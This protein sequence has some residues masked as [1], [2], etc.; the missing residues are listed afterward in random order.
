MMSTLTR[1]L[2]ASPA[3]P[4][5]HELLRESVTA[6]A[7]NEVL[8]ILEETIGD[9]LSSSGRGQVELSIGLSP[10]GSEMWTERVRED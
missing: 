1:L 8:T 5:I 3:D 6:A 7:Y 9:E 4:A 10:V 2:R